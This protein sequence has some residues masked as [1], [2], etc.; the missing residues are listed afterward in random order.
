MFNWLSFVCHTFYAGKS[1]ESHL[2]ISPYSSTKYCA[3]FLEE[4]RYS[5]TFYLKLILKFHKS[6]WRFDAVCI[7]YAGTNTNGNSAVD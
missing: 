3:A 6:S 7:A 2:M 4:G 5:E 1:F